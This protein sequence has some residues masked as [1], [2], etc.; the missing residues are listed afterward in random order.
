M[1]HRATL[2]D[3]T[4]TENSSF[5]QAEGNSTI[6]NYGRSPKFRT[7]APAPRLVAGKLDPSAHQTHRDAHQ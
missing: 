3:L 2:H 4:S 7:T 5:M 6:S 1:L